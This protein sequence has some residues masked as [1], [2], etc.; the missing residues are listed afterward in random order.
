MLILMPAFAFGN[1]AATLVG[2]N[3][4]ANAP[5]RAARGAWL[6]VMMDMVV[7][8]IGGGLLVL[9]APVLMQW[10]AKDPDV[11]TIGTSLLRITCG[12]YLFAGL[13]I[14]LGRALQGAGDTLASMVLTVVSLWGIQLPLAYVLNRVMTPPTNG[15]WW[16]ISIAVTLHGL[17][18]T[19]W[20]QAGHWKHRSV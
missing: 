7:M 3:L 16:A 10:F 4:G 15:I 19:I 11:I 18:V 14:V 13:S 17:M 9:Y 12:F 6:A 5:G 20:F 1:A 2:Q 8:A